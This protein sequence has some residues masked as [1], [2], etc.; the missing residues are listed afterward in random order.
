MYSIQN[1]E[2]ISSNLQTKQWRNTTE[3]YKNGK[4]TECE[5][6]QR[7]MVN[8]ITN[9]ICH[10]SNVRI[11]VVDFT[12]RSNPTPMKSLD[13]FEWSEDFDGC[14]QSDELTNYFNF[15]MVCDAGGSQTRTMREVY[16]FIKSQLEHLLKYP[17]ESSNVRFI[18]ILDGDTSYKAMPK[19][20]YL[21]NSS[22]YAQIKN[23]L[24]QFQE[25]YLL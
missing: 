11:N 20:H 19:F 18:N 7:R 4:H 2:I 12:M 5:M 6:Y 22:K 23:N 25:W 3:W 24:F 16:H 21:L 1:M 13:G 10:K 14:I 15:K 8:K 17:D 9:S